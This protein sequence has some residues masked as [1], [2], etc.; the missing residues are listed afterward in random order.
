VDDPGMVNDSHPLLLLASASVG[1]IAALRSSLLDAG[2]Q[3]RT[4]A[5]AD[6]ALEAIL[7]FQVP[8]IVMLDADL[9]GRPLGQI[10]ASLNGDER[11]FPIIVIADQ[12]IPEW[13][14][15]LAEGVIDGILPPMLPPFHWSAQIEMTLRTFRQ[16]RELEQL[17]AM[18]AM[19][20]DIDAVT[21]LSNRPALLSML[22]RET[23]RVQ[24]MNT[25]LSLIRFDIDDLSHWQTRLGQ[26]AW[27]ELAKEAVGRVQRLLRTY[28]LFGRVGIAGFALGLPGCAPVQAVSLAERIR[29]EVFSVPFRAEHA[30]VR[31]SASFGI[32]PSHGRS[33]LIVLRDAEQALQAARLAGPEEIRTA[34]DCGRPLPPA[35]FF[36]ASSR[37]DV[38]TW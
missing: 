36:S 13:K 35:A 28:D 38:L 12:G 26:A 25:S 4:A 18:T 19:D 3:L 31:L 1:L 17:R 8:T 20:R 16:A 33:P 37:K 7:D 24:R 15:R 27:D 10:L 2:I 11:R 32:A 22:F 34:G 29:A 14:E 5:S 30:A 23:D 21:G 6:A 9:P